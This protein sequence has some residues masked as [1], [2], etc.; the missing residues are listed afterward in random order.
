MLFSFFL[1]MRLSP[2]TESCRNLPDNKNRQ[3]E[4]SYRVFVTGATGLVGSHA[5]RHLLDRGYQVSAM[6]R[7]TSDRSALVELA[8]THE[9][10]LQIVECDLLA[11]QNLF[12][13]LCDIDAVVHTAACIDPHGD[14]RNLR[15][16]NVDGTRAMLESA[17]A[18]GVAHFVHISSLSVITGDRDCYGITEEEPLQVCRE[19]YAN[20]KIEAEQIVMDASVLKKINVT[21]LRPGFIY[22]PNEKTW[23]PRVIRGIKNRTSMMVGDGSKETNLIYVENL[24]RAIGLAVMN[25]VSYG[26]IY[27]LTD[28]EKVTKLQLFQALADG[29]ELPY[30][31]LTIPMFLARFI[32]N[33]A[34]AIAVISPPK[35]KQVLG[36]YSR[37]ALRLVGMNQGFDI[38]K[39]ERQLGYTNRIP[40]A[41]GMAKTLSS[42]A[43]ER[44]TRNEKKSHGQALGS[45]A[46][47]G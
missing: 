9:G 4:K 16:I 39:A 27:N 34:S 45:E 19:A 26:Q 18:A 10:N 11:S 30:T 41:Q 7:A 24:C 3:S 8:R 21:A 33:S 29:L 28:G 38:S 40:F 37:P 12:E 5:V 43:A 14:E 31:W 42:F 17:I 6:V 2:I 25:P 1:S 35:L 46:I 32:V 44:L 23:L 15:K 20:S 22:G 36:K 47:R 13:L